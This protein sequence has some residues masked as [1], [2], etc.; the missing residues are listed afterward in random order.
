[1]QKILVIGASGQLSRSLVGLAPNNLQTITAAG[2]P[3]LDLLDLASVE[4]VLSDNAPDVV[5][6]AAAYTA[7]DTAETDA[8]QAFAVNETGPGQLAEMC[9][10]K[11][12]PLIHISTDYVYDGEKSGVYVE[13]D[14]VAPLGIYGRSKL[15]GELLVS[16]NCKKHIILRTAWVHS[17]YGQNFVKTMLRLAGSR[18]ELSVVH[19][20]IGTP[21]YAPHLAECIRSIAGTLDDA[22]GPDNP[23]GVYHAAGIGGGISWYNLAVKIFEWS[24]EMSGPTALVHPITTDQYPTPARR[25][26]NSRLE[27]AKLNKVFDLALP[28]WKVGGRACVAELISNGEFKS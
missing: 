18:D 11:D 23:W 26:G 4:R 15:A 28:D 7:V 3:D 27:C 24:E 1:M 21:T 17:P 13:D 20:Q 16:Q 9:E 6:N 2:R 12:I 25:P 5:V 8:A 14:P 19:D 10:K 22:D